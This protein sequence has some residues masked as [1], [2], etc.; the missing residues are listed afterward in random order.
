MN[1]ITKQ[2]KIADICLAIGLGIVFT[3]LAL[4]YFDVL[5]K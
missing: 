5:V 3:V 1:E 4:A 2:E